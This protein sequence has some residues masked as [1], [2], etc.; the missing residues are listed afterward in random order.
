MD[1][2]T[3]GNTPIGGNPPEKMYEIKADRLRSTVDAVSEYGR[4]TEGT[5]VNR[6]SF[7]DADMAA[8]QWLISE[9]EASGLTAWMDAVGNV[10]GRWEAGDGPAVIVG[11]HLD[12]VPEGGRLDGTLGVLAGLECVRSLKEQGFK[13]SHPIEVLAT[14]EE[15]GRF[16]GMLGS[17]ALAGLISEDWLRNAQDDTGLS[18][19]E[20]M[21][22]QGLNA[23]DALA[24]RR[25]PATVKAF[26]E[27]HIEQGPVLHEKGIPVGV[28]TGISGCA[29]WSVTLTGRPN[30]AGTTPMDMR[31]DAFAGLASFATTIPQIIE[32]HGTDESRLTIG[33]VDLSPNFP[34]TV[35]G[36][37]QF[38]LI[39]RD[40][41]EKVMHS[42]SDACWAN[43]EKSATAH[44]LQW[45][46]QMQSWLAPQ[47]C[48]ESMI[49]LLE[50]QAERL[51]LPSL[52]MPSGAGH[53]TQ[54]MAAITAAGLIFVPSIG[55]ISHSPD[56]ATDW[57][58]ITKGCK[59]LINAL[60]ELAA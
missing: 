6:P 4:S 18:L 13:P 51:N 36:E 2:T 60:A 54:S 33:K 32:T 52:T 16:G 14:S 49:S 31:A 55:G 22:R 56:E 43:L 1:N 41:N 53:D 5:G 30:H 21:H 44:N 17:Q 34:H 35:P 37:A 11:S 23:L 58:D 7:S 50:K 24:I 47:P 39:L 59:V 28:V 46:V 20:A 45:D 15:E 40:M 10:F 25:D 57:R 8:R 12:S 3:I 38:T 42:L 26:L 29:N 19:Q 27:L 48:H 9:M